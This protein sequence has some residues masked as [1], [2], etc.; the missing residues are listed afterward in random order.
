MRHSSTHDAIPIQHEM[1]N[2][3]VH[4][5]LCAVWYTYVSLCDV[6]LL[7]WPISM[8]SFAVR[9]PMFGR[10]CHVLRAIRPLNA[11]WWWSQI[12]LQMI[13]DTIDCQRLNL[14]LCDSNAATTNILYRLLCVS[15]DS[16]WSDEETKSQM[17]NL[18][19]MYCSIESRRTMMLVCQQHGVLCV[20]V[21]AARVCVF[22]L[23]YH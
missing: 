12:A 21:F 6:V 14:R 3:F 18:D 20:S 15:D 5:L 16:H 2:V 1:P 7:P 13:F 4:N 22:V 11:E 8:L 23:I 10:V 19:S 9:S 17:L